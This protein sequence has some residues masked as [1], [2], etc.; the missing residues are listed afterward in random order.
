MTHRYTLLVRGIVITGHDE[1]DVSA[2]AWADDTVIALGTDGDVHGISRGDS[3]VV[4]LAGA[5][6][7]P[8]GAGLDA[9]WPVDAS[10]EVGGRADLAVI[11]EDPRRVSVP[12]SQALSPVAV[13]RAGQVVAGRLPGTHVEAIGLPGAHVEWATLAIVILAV[14]ELPRAVAFYR[15]AFG[16]PTDVDTP[17]Y[18]EFGLPAGMRL[19]LYQREAFGSNVGETPHRTP[20]E[21]LSATELYLFP[22]DLEAAAERLIAAGARQ[23]SPLARRDWGD[24]VAYFA[25]PDGNL[26]ALARAPGD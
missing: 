4:D 24:E 5:W 26:I 23:L 12:G 19:G 17:A 13:V 8:L 18:V 15:S 21:A 22:N 25:D 6:V 9:C 20:A 10:L 1:P 16:W 14:A 11:D 2:V 3:D 7:I